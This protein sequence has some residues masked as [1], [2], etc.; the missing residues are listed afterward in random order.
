MI[1]DW[2]TNRVY[3]S[4]RLVNDYP[5][6]YANIRDAL[7][8]FNF[9]PT[10]LAGTKDVWAR[11]YMPI[12]ISDSRFIEYRYDPDYLQGKRKGFRGFKTYPDIVCQRNNLT[13]PIKTDLIIDGGNIVKSKNTIILT[14]KVAI[15]NR[16]TKTETIN[17]LKET[18]E[19]EN[20]ILVPWFKKE[21]FGHIDGILRFIDEKTVLIN[22]IE[23]SNSRLIRKIQNN[24]IEIK[25][26]EFEIK[27]KDKLNWAYINFLQTKDFILFPKLQIDED[28]QAFEKIKLFVPDYANRKRIVQVDVRDLVEYGGGGLNC[29]SWTTKE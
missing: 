8:S 18:F 20:V 29:A 13:I 23:K 10:P 17:R 6:C 5:K 24:G 19:V 9:D 21:K 22:E 14:D 4:D 25:W 2:Q 7:K 28:D 15:E 3:I 1:P 26:F 16:L 12:Q 27:K 11:D